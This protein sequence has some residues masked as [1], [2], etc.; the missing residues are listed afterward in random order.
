MLGRIKPNSAKAARLTA[1]IAQVDKGDHHLNFQYRHKIPCCSSDMDNYDTRIR[2]EH[3]KLIGTPPELAV[4]R[5]L[6]E[7]ATLEHYGVEFYP[8]MDANRTKM[9]VGVGPECMVIV[10]PQMEI[11]QRSVDA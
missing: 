11:L 2:R 3:S 7:A 1:L 5:F 8:A 9:F 6:S 10:S 4:E